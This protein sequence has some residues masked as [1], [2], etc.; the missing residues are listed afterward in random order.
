[1][2]YCARGCVQKC[3]LWPWWRSK[4]KRTETFKLAICPDHPRRPSP[5]KVCMLVVS[6]K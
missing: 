3:Y 2:T 6:R 4:Q 5:L 1:M